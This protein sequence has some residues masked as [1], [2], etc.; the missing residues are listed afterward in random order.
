MPNI[1]LFFQ[2]HQPRRLRRY[3]IFDIDQNHDYEN[4][5]LN[6][7]VLQK[8]SDKCY[9]PAN[10]LLFDLLQQ[11]EGNLRVSFSLT[12]TLIDQLETQRPDVL[13]SFQRL[14]ETGY[15]EW[16]NE[17]Y[18]HSLASL[19]SPGEFREQVQKHHQKIDELFGQKAVTFCN[20]EMIYNNEIAQAVGEMGYQVMLTEGA[21][22]ILPGGSSRVS[23]R[24]ASRPDLTVLLRDYRLSDDI[25]FRFSATDWFEYPLTARKYARWLS[26][27]AQT[28]EVINLFM[29]YETFGEHQWSETGIFEFL[30]E[31]PEEILKYPDFR[32]QT[33]SQII[34]DPSSSPLLDVKETIS[35]ADTERDVTAW[36]GNGM[37]RDALASLYQLEDKVKKS[38][39]EQV[40]KTWR[41]LQTSDHFYYMC[42]KWFADGDVHTY[43]NP[44]ESP[45]DAYISY[46]NILD[47]FDRKLRK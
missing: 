34:P 29:D 14:N 22:R 33:P 4:E 42:T 20:T 40:L 10:N 12:G 16:L 5:T 19:Y 28:T 8:V 41:M 43:F 3:T 1:C 47:D 36:T 15:V 30:R 35:W 46:M 17:T 32:F 24:A 45:Y 38:G 2:V 9:L 18:D 23:W 27:N 11:H 44:W 39:D 25:S 7:E 13:E 31:L 37:Q 26:Q 6:R 21:D